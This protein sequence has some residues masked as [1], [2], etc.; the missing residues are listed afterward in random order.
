MK[1]SALYTAL[2][3]KELSNLSYVDDNGALLPSK[4][5]TVLAYLNDCL[6]DLFTRYPMSEKRMLISLK[7]NLSDYKLTLPFAY[8]QR[9]NYPSNPHY[10]TDSDSTPYT[11]DLIKILSAYDSCG[12]RID[13]N[14]ISRRQGVYTPYP[15]TITVLRPVEGAPLSLTYQAYHPV[16]PIGDLDYEIQ[17]PRSLEQ[18]VTSYVAAMIFASMNTPESQQRAQ[19]LMTFYQSIDSSLLENDLLSTSTTSEGTKFHERGFV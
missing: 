7:E 12:D 14:D 8:S 15:D 3:V 1:V 16:V 11:G 9:A 4:Y 2:A 13:F 10:I 6:V 5:P 18:A 19:Q 17:I